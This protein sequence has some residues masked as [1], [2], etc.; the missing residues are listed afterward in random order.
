M[1]SQAAYEDFANSI[2][3][4]FM[5]ANSGLASVKTDQIA[6]LKKNQDE[7]RASIKGLTLKFANDKISESLYA[8]MVAEAETNIEKISR[9]IS[10]LSQ[11]SEM[12]EYFEKL[13][14]VL[15]KTF[16]LASN[17]LSE[18]N[19]DQR[20][21]DIL[22]L[23]ELTTFELTINNEKELKIKLFDVLDKLTKD[24]NFSMEAPSGVEPLSKAL[25]ASV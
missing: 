11:N 9:Q 24:V 25:Q 1:M 16:E 7:M 6:A 22:K 10:E 23:L 2:K 4:Q 5:A 18:G 21:D 14:S 13:P 3:E 20:K 12:E 15:C 19:D 17:T 8:E